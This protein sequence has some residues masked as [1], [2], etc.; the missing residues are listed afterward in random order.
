[1]FRT[2]CLS[3][4]EH[5]LRKTCWDSHLYQYKTQEKMRH[6]AGFSLYSR[7]RLWVL[8]E[9]QMELSTD[10]P[11]SATAQYM[12]APERTDHCYK[13]TIKHI[14]Q[15]LENSSI[16]SPKALHQILYT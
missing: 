7:P 2:S 15:S 10:A 9:L 14:P 5:H 12:Y 13:Y 8:G 16:T 6:T 1:M 11:E 4:I 3:A